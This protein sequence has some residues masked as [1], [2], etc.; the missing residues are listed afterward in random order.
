MK[1]HVNVIPHRPRCFS[2]CG[3][4]LL[5]HS[6]AQEQPIHCFVQPYSTFVTYLT[7][8]PWMMTLN[9]ATIVIY[10]LYCFIFFKNTH[11]LLFY[12]LIRAIQC[13]Y[14]AKEIYSLVSGYALITQ[15]ACTVDTSVV[16]WNNQ[17]I[18]QPLLIRPI[19]QSWAD[20]IHM[21]AQLK[22]F[23]GFF[24]FIY[25]SLC[26]G[27]KIYHW[28]GSVIRHFFTLSYILILKSNRIISFYL[29]Q[30]IPIGKALVLF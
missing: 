27:D 25:E 10:C 1:R 23:S 4:H 6:P 15:E 14:T 2:Q 30:C 18:T 24:S 28:F 22:P 19:Y 16:L 26:T 21:D 29:Y 17:E 8:L 7:P 13:H 12:R 11:F 3:D 9:K 5:G 20:A